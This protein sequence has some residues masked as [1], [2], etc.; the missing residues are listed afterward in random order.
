MDKH[1]NLLRVENAREELADQEF[2]FREALLVAMRARPTTGPDRY[3]ADDV[4]EAAGISRARVYQILE[5]EKGRSN[6]AG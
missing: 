3:T 5:E 4:A 6:G 2:R 1:V